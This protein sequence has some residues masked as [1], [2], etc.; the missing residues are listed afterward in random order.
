[1]LVSRILLGATAALALVVGSAHAADLPVKAQPA[2]W[3][4]AGLYVGGSLGARSAQND[5]TV[6]SLFPNFTVPPFVPFGP[7][8][9]SQVPSGSFDSTAARFGG[10]AGYNWSVAPSW[11][12]GVEADV[13]WANN[14]KTATAISAAT[15]GGIGAI[16]SLPVTTIKDTWDG[17][18]RGRVGTLL[19]P[20]TLLFGT[21]G[22]AWQRMEVA[23]FCPAF[24]G[25]TTFCTFNHSESYSKTLT[26]WTAGVG[27]EQRM[28]GHWLARLEYRYA[29]FQEFSQLFFNSTGPF[30]DDRFT[31]NVKLQTHTVNVG[32]GYKF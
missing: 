29:D 22:V 19:T 10:Y 25:A 11:I 5:Y 18:V 30:F 28:W 13:G 15:V 27:I 20:N 24:G 3:S 14:N 21:A 23:A 17:S 9:F 12:V 7:V 31:A 6:S 16:T 1:M 4:W 8:A 2:A 26:G 32:L